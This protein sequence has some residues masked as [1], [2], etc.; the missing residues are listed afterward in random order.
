MDSVCV[1]SVL[2]LCSL[3]SVK[4]RCVSRVCVSSG[5][6]L[7]LKYDSI[8]VLFWRAAAFSPSS[9]SSSLHTNKHI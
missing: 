3:R 1:Q 2:M 7:R 4:K 8:E 5:G 6:L 9:S